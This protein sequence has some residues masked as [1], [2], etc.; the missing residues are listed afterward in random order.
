MMAL[1]DKAMADPDEAGGSTLWRILRLLALGLAIAMLMGIATGFT[2]A[3]IHNGKGL[4]LKAVLVYGLV[5]LGLAGCGWLVRRD[6]RRR[7]GEYPLTAKERTNRNII[8]ACG[9]MGLV[10]A[11]AMTFASEKG[12]AGGH[13]A[14][15]SNDPLPTAVAAVLVLMIGVI[16]PAI[17]IYW[18]RVIDEQEADAYKTGST[19]ALSLYGMGAPAWWLAW[20][21]GFA[22]EPNGF[23]IYYAVV[24]TVGV[25]W[26]WKKYR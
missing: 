10:S 14:I 13:L 23:I 6:L 9:V 15:F 4:T 2:M 7:A 20:R 8:I 3:V 24:T 17:T 26:I 5:A 12:L 11:I 22:P 18:W 21:G 25:I 1:K 19:V 16:L